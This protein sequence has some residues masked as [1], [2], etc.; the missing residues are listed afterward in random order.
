M[1]FLFFGLLRRAKVDKL[2]GLRSFVEED[3]L[4]LEIGMEDGPLVKKRDGLEQLM[5][6]FPSILLAE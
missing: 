6:Q 1:F 2:D 3:V 5:E 4:Q